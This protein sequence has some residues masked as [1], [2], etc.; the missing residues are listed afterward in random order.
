MD[1]R[2][3]VKRTAAFSALCIGGETIGAREEVSASSGELQVPPRVL[4]RT[5]IEVP[6][7]GIDC[8]V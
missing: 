6:C 7:L 3:F 8:S 5:D 4:G 1:R 2:D